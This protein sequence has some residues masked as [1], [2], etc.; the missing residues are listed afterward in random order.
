MDGFTAGPGTGYPAASHT[1]PQGAMPL[2]LAL[3]LELA[4]Q[5]QAALPLL[6]QPPQNK[7]GHPRGRPFQ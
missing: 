7:N 5:S 4:P 6:L 3:E 1:H 2:A